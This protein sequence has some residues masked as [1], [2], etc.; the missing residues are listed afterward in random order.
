[1]RNRRSVVTRSRVSDVTTP[2]KIVRGEIRAL[3]AYHVPPSAGLIKLDAMENPYTLPSA[4]QSELTARLAAVAANRYPDAEAAQL[5]AALR[6]AMGIA[7][8]FDILLGNGSDEIIQI[9]AQSV[10]AP[11]ATLLSVEP[12]FVMFKMIATFCGLN[13]AGVPL[14]PEFSLDTEAVLGACERHKPAVIFLAYPNN[15]T[16][17]LF[18][19]ES[20][21]RIIAAATGLV[22]VD[23]AYFA[24]SSRTFLDELGKYPNVVLMRT[25]SKLGLAGL[26][27]GLLIGRREW[28]A[29]F[30]KVRL[31]YNLNV[32]TQTAA[33][34]ALGHYDVLLGQAAQIVKD[35]AAL[36]SSLAKLPGVAVYPSEANFILFRVPEGAATFEALR[37]RG[38]LIKNVGGA[39]PLLKNCLRVTV[40]TP[41]ENTAFLAALTAALTAALHASL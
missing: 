36:A 10:A 39:H 5:K 14:K 4:W 22:V 7:D 31:P 37:A 33:T 19:I 13:Y 15:P 8:D 35:R 12:A 38:I 1:M 11:G 24:F 34:F 21:R 23:E 26:R 32:L 6:S 25:V 17:N 18:D 41:E 29:E 9:V 2:D 28:I 3:S 16:G 20:V 30:E 27:L 40:G